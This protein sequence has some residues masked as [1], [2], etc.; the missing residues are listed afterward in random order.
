[1]PSRDHLAVGTET[2]PLV[3]DLGPF[4]DNGFTVIHEIIPGIA[5]HAPSLGH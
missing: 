1:M 3:A 5:D 4:A 2:V